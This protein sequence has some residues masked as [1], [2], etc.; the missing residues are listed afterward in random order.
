MQCTG[1]GAPDEAVRRQLL[2]GE[3]APTVHTYSVRLV[4]LASVNVSTLSGCQS[5]IPN[6]C[7]TMRAPGFSWLS[8][9]G[10]SYTFE[11]DR[12]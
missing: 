2:F 4:P 3:F 7:D 5:P 8:S 1:G 9:R 12:R 10:R 6:W 11:D